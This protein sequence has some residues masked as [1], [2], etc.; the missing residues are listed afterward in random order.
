[1]GTFGSALGREVNWISNWYDGSF[2][3]GG[4]NP[5][6]WENH[7]DRYGLSLFWSIQ[8]LTSIGYGNIAPV[9]R[10]EVRKMHVIVRIHF[11]GRTVTV[12]TDSLFCI[13]HFS[14]NTSA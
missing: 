5:I 12:W 2:I 11:G 9:T 4:I 1:M 8:S 10:L 7:I 13:F 14:F 6:G 3:E